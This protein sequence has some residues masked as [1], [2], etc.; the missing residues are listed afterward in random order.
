MDD[1]IKLLSTTITTD[2][3][4][5][6]IETLTERQVFCRVQSI[7]RSEFYA[8]AQNDLHPDYIFRISHFRDYHGEK[9]LKYKDYTGTEK[10]YS[11]LRTYRPADEDAIEITATE[12]TGNNVQN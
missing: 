7:T 9:L 10:V 11:V 2:T 6:Q 5:N 1:V 4:G 8:A 12:R 3:N